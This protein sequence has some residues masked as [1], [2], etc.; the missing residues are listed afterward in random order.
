MPEPVRLCT[1][2]SMIRPPRRVTARVL[3]VL[4][5]AGFGY[6]AS[7]SRCLWPEQ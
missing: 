6:L 3:V 2:P 7:G 4:I 5:A 1:R